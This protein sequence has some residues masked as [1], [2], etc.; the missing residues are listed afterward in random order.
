[1]HERNVL[2]AEI[3]PEEDRGREPDRDILFADSGVHLFLID[4]P[5]RQ[6]QLNETLMYHYVAISFNAGSYIH[7]PVATEITLTESGGTHL[8]QDTDLCP[9]APPSWW[10]TVGG[11]GTITLD[12]YEPGFLTRSTAQALRSV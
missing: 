4:R 7:Y 6:A 2:C 1:M 10:I 11:V 9:D 5:E 12:D 3:V 8:E